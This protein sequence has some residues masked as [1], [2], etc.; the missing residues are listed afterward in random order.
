MLEVFEIYDHNKNQ[1]SKAKIGVKYTNLGEKDGERRKAKRKEERP[2]R[3]RERN[4][5]R[6]RKRGGK[7]KKGIFPQ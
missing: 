3:E 5:E 2:E 1:L 4:L 7:G 6:V